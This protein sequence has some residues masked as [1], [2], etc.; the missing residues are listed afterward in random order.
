M[1]LKQK[2]HVCAYCRFN[3]LDIEM[4]VISGFDFLD[5]L[6]D[7]PQIVFITSSRVCYESF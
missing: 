6:K 3:F 5:G 2:L 1:Q 4:P 7:K